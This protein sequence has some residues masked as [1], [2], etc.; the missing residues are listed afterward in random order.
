MFCDN[1]SRTE[2]ESKGISPKEMPVTKYR[3]GSVLGTG[4]YHRTHY[5]VD[6]SLSKEV[7]IKIIDAK[8]ISEDRQRLLDNKL[9]S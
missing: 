1:S 4:K 8:A 6:Q 2:E 5:A 7:I 9:V 3:L